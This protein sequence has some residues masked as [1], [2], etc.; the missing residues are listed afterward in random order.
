M[1]VKSLLPWSFPSASL[2]THNVISAAP[3]ERIFVKHDT[4]DFM[5]ICPEKSKFGYL[6]PKLSDTLHED[7][8]TFYC[9][10]TNCH[11]LQD[12]TC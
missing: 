7:L 9:Y 4:G 1:N 8:S 11:G 3:T 10:I 6:V 2:F 12:A 5:E